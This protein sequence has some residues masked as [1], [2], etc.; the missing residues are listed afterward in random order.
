MSRETKAYASDFGSRVHESRIQEGEVREYACD[1][2]G[3]LR[4][5]TIASA[6]MEAQCG[7]LTL[8][9]LDV[10]NGVATAQA[11]AASGGYESL[12]LSVTTNAGRVLAQMFRVLVESSPNAG[13]SV[14]WTP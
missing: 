10:T 6:T 4:G 11:T 14:T 12:R 2:N 1:F 5:E 13:S 8:A 7:R 3:A 9:S